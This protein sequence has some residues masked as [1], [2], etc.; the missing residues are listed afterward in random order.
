[1]RKFQKYIDRRH[2]HWASALRQWMTKVNTATCDQYYE[3]R[4]GS[5]GFFSLL[6]LHVPIVCVNGPIYQIDRRDGHITFTPLTHCITTFRKQS[7]PGNV[8]DSL[9]RVRLRYPCF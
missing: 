8:R 7:W 1:M 3:M 5:G 2:Y 4:Y 6:T 9:P